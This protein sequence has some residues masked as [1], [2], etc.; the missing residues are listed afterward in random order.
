MKVVFDLREKED[1]KT[2]EII[3]SAYD[4]PLGV[5]NLRGEAINSCIGCWSCW[6]KTPGRCIMNDRMSEIYKEYI[7]SDTVVLLMDT[8]HGFIN[9][10]AKAFFDRTIP[11]Y[12]PH[13]EIVG[14]ECHHVA[15]YESYP[16]MVFYFDK[17]ILCDAEEQVIE[18]YLYRVAYHFK[19]NAYRIIIDEETKLVP[20]SSRRPKNKN[21]EFGSVESIEK[22]VVYN[23]S[24]RKSRSNTAL[25]LKGISRELGE[26]VEIRDLKEKNSWQE[27]AEKFKHDEH[28]MFFMPLY[29]HAMP[30]HVMEFIESLST[31]E[32]SISFFIQ[33][34][35]PESSQSYYVEAYFEHLSIKL[36]RTYLGTVIKGGVESLQGR[37]IEAQE[38]MIE[39][40]INAIEN[41]VND[42]KFNLYDIRRLARPIRFGKVIEILFNI[43]GK[44]FIDSF[45]DQQLIANDAYDIS[46]DRPYEI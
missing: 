38:K 2:L 8:A 24:P 3:K 19:A 6:L 18:D 23:G 20:L 16:D 33:S 29:V 32:G 43:A 5:F 42:G 21:I 46:F 25:I 35:F 7:N 44:K 34:G 27:W 28:V 4:E 30:S 37:P 1:E 9:H 11:H 12:H 41:L 22:L 26:K 17:S 36:G 10:R 31:S 39:P 14:G 13:I 40:M 45:W 15:R